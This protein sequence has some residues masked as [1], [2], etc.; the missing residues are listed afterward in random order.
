MVRT[1]LDQSVPALPC[2]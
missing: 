2:Q 1:F